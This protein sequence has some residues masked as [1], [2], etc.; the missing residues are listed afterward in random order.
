MAIMVGYIPLPNQ[1]ELFEM[2]WENR[3]VNASILAALLAS[4]GR[5]VRSSWTDR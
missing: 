3:I 4:R 2:R 1:A 5:V